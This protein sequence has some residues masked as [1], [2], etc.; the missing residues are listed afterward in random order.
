MT[1]QAGCEPPREAEAILLKDAADPASLKLTDIAGIGIVE[2]EAGRHGDTE[3]WNSAP[4]RLLAWAALQ[5]FAPASADDAQ[6][7][8]PTS[9]KS[10][11]KR[12]AAP[13]WPAPGIDVIGTK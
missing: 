7:R 12:A 11:A 9:R 2:D 4:S 8:N 6:L 13:S 10:N 5:D 3:G 1:F